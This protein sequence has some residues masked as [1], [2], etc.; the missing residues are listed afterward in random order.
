MTLKESNITLL[1]DRVVIQLDKMLDHTITSSGVM[2]PNTEL[3]ETDGGKL[4]T[5]LS[6]KSHV[7]QGT[8]Q[9]LSAKAQE[10]LPELKIGDK[11]FVAQHS[12]NSS[13]YFYPDRTKLIQDFEGYI[14]I[15]HTLIEAKI[16]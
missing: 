3:T 2:V 13:N 9:L 14:C 7:P 1:G 10:L 4:T 8:V 5:R 11:V 16:N 6:N 15:P 12:L